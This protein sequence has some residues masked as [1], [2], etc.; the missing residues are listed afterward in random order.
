MHFR[1]R[2]IGGTLEILAAKHRGSIPMLLA[3]LSWHTLLPSAA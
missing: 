3:C 2:Q 1:A